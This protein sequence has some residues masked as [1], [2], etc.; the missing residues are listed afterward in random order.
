M[1][2]NGTVHVYNN[3]KKFKKR[4]KQKTKENLA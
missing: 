4:T 3:G 2:G 1:D